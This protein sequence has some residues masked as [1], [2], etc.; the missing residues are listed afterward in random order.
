MTQP[1]VPE[2]EVDTLYN[3]SNNKTS[4]ASVFH[5]RMRG[6]M[7]SVNLHWMLQGLSLQINKSFSRS[8]AL[9]VEI[10]QQDDEGN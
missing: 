2:N 3:I 6:S 10:I 9:W 1:F 7:L 5:N 8:T 4:Y